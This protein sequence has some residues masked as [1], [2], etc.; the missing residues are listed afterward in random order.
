[1][2][3]MLSFKSHEKSEINVRSLR[4]FRI[5]SVSNFAITREMHSNPV[6]TTLDYTLPRL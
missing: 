3:V 1:V 5:P 6:I 4:M 2:I